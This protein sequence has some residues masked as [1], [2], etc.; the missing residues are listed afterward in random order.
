MFD[1]CGDRCLQSTTA[2][3]FSMIWLS[4]GLSIFTIFVG[5][6]TTTLTVK[7][8]TKDSDVHK[9]LGNLHLEL[10]S[11][12]LTTTPLLKVSL[13]LNEMFSSAVILSVGGGATVDIAT[14]NK[15][16]QTNQTKQ[17]K[18]N[19][20]LPPPPPNIYRKQY[21]YSRL[22]DEYDQEMKNRPFRGGAYLIIRQS[23]L[24][25]RCLCRAVWRCTR[26]QKNMYLTLIFPQLLK[27]NVF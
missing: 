13:L 22:L 23:L 15:H 14:K 19:V 11:T 5:F 1:R 21:F 17:K 6:L 18:P 4:V 16:K 25:I 10:L 27:T 12:N 3:I 7:I 26:K 8:V 9:L 24:L 2:K 20:S